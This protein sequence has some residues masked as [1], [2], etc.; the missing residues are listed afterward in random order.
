MSHVERDRRI[1]LKLF[2]LQGDLAELPR[3]GARLIE[4]RDGTKGLVL[5]GSLVCNETWAAAFE[6]FI[7]SLGGEGAVS[8]LLARLKPGTS[9]IA[10]YVPFDSPYQENNGFTLAAVQLLA[11]LGLQLDVVPLNFDPRNPTHL[12]EGY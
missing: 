6:R 8:D 9:T 7:G 12:S 3:S 5:E 4:H 11:R 1:E 2:G 10:I